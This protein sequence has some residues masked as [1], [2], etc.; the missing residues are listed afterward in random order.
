MNYNE[1]YE[2]WLAD[3]IIDNET[4]AELKGI[5]D[6]EKEIEDRF[7]RELEF[8]TGGL[9]GVLG[10]GTNRLN[11]YTIRKATQGLANYIL[12][13]DA[14]KPGMGVA[15][16]HDCRRMSPEFSTEAA[17]VLNANGIKTYTFD[18]LRPTPLLSFA[19]RHLG[20][21]AGI[22]VT[23]SHNPPEY[24][25]YKVYWADGG[26][27]PYPRDE[28]IIAEVL[29]IKG[30]DMVK[31][32]P[33]NE[34]AA[35]GLFNIAPPSV[36]D[37]FIKNV[38]EQCL[39]PE[40]IPRSDIKIV[41]TPLH[42]AGNLSVQR[43]LRE[44]GFKNVFVVKEQE[45]SDG[46][47]PTV[48]YPNPEEKAAFSLALKLAKEK[49]A[50]VI[51]ATDP[52][53]DRVGVAVKHG[54]DY[55]FLT[56][57]QAGVLLTEY[58]V[59]QMTGRGRLPKNGAIISTIVSTDMAR[60]VAEAN[61]LTYMEVLTGFKYIGE[62]IKEFEE[63]G[64]HTYILGFEESYGYLA[65][66]YARDKDAVAASLLVCEAAA[67]YRKKGLTLYDALLELYEKYGIF[68]EHIESITLKGVDGLNDIKRVMAAL[69]ETPPTELAGSTV[70]EARDYK[71]RTIK[72]TAT[73]EVTAATLP[74]SDVLYYATAD[75][76]WACVRPSGTEP[77]IKLYF[78]AKLSAGSTEDEIT[79]KLKAITADLKAVVD[80]VLQ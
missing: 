73:G 33:Q 56:G 13:S 53:C 34:A 2:Q 40:I 9:R 42:G 18:S 47:F 21:V 63:T 17:L 22:V 77:K 32:M 3:P 31:T 72:N 12:K 45:Q 36:D 5:A 23:A 55:Q 60:A 78:G 39:N 51:I 25:G 74:V 24:N 61:G 20:C 16:A 71:N 69:R 30:F 37:I 62:K 7:Y 8:G 19:V 35:Q 52:D 49:D 15:I 54:G 64:S 11:I 6:N 76:S 70:T 75:G 59:S 4:K 50:D 65:G 41:F 66:T 57:N 28:E 1:V 38:K 80:R 26:Q 46:N 79:A 48:S 29:K 27:C 44:T 14:Y 68:R 67:F 43:A 10:A 58:L